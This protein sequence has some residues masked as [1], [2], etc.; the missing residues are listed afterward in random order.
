MVKKNWLCVKNW[1][2]KKISFKKLTLKKIGFK[3]LALKN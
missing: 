1:L 3:N 2:L